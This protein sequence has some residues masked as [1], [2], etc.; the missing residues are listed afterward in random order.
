MPV[1]TTYPGVYIE[2]RPSGVRTIAGVS[3]SVTAFVGEAA[4]GPADTPVRVFSVS[5]YIRTFGPLLDQ[6][7]PMGH[8]VQHFFTNGG[9]EA[10]IVRA[11][12]ADAETASVTLQNG[13]PGGDDVL[14]LTAKGKGAWANLA[15]GVGVDVQ[16]DRAGATNP[17]D[18]FNL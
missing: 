15:G 9:G 3:T 8:A 16:P 11:L 18:L 5:E 12:S 10:V 17:D 1:Q 4:K 7:R 2:E 14:M 13:V 6:D